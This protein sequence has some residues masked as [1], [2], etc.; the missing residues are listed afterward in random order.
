MREYPEEIVLYE[1]EV[2]QGGKRVKSAAKNRN[3]TSKDLILTIKRRE[4]SK[5]I[6]KSILKLDGNHNENCKKVKVALYV[7][8]QIFLCVEYKPLLRMLAVAIMHPLSPYEGCMGTPDEK[9][10]GGVSQ[11]CVGSDYENDRNQEQGGKDAYVFTPALHAIVENRCVMR[12]ARRCSENAH[13]DEERSD[14]RA[15]G[16]RDSPYD[17]RSPICDGIKSEAYRK[18]LERKEERAGDVP[19]APSSSLHATASMSSSPLSC[20]S[21]SVTAPVTPPPGSAEL[22]ADDSTVEDESTEAHF[23][24]NDV[25]QVAENPYRKSL[26]SFV[27]GSCGHSIFLPANMLLNAIIE[28]RGV[29]S[30]ILTSAKVLPGYPRSCRPHS[31]MGGG[32]IYHP[33]SVRTSSTS[34]GGEGIYDGASPQTP[35]Q[36]SPAGSS[37]PPVVP[38]RMPATGGLP[39]SPLKAYLSASHL[40]VENAISSFLRLPQPSNVGGHCLEASGAL[41][42][43]YLQRVH[44][45][46]MAAGGGVNKWSEYVSSNALINS[47][48]GVRVAMAK[49]CSEFMKNKVFRHMFTDLMEEQIL[50]RYGGGGS[51]SALTCML[52]RYGCR[53]LQNNLEVLAEGPSKGNVGK[54]KD[55]GGDSVSAGAG[56]GNGNEGGKDDEVAEEEEEEE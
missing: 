32:N 16:G 36:S 40:D 44:R 37:P 1:G 6:L 30:A 28:C 7:L 29:G 4:A 47:L 3:C 23:S 15:L 45:C 42:L 54:K 13:G 53:A 27:S 31:R 22:K 2:V 46:S 8:A 11:D 5:N 48:V 33:L 38:H 12:K 9:T 18:W 52:N 20:D 26:L 50:A 10:E 17:T 34:A 35:H 39:P 56:D 19:V 25:I 24:C 43:A 55:R 14:R 49:E 41:A 51:E 21:A